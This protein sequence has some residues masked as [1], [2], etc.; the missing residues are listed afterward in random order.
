MSAVQEFVRRFEDK[1]AAGLV[2]FKVTLDPKFNGTMEEVCEEL[3]A[4]DDAINRGDYEYPVECIYPIE[5]RILAQFNC[6]CTSLMIVAG[7]AGD[8]CAECGAPLE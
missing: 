3:N 5:E 6:D 2:D 1:Q 7:M 8:E 4:M